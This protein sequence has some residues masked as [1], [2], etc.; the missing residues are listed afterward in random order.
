M[1]VIHPFRAVRPKKELVREVATLPY[2]VLNSQEAYELG[3]D[4][5]YSYLHI[6]KAEID[7]SKEILHDDK[8]VYE[9]AR[10]NF[11]KFKEKEWLIK[12]D[13]PNLY[14]YELTMNGR[15]QLGLVACTS[16]QEYLDGKIKK[17][18]FT[19]PEKELDR[20]RHSDACDANTSPIFLTYQGNIDLDSAMRKW[21]EIHEP[22]YDFTS[23]YEV[24]HRVWGIDDKEFTQQ[25]IDTFADEEALYIADG[26]HRTESAVKVGQLRQ[27]EYPNAKSDAEF[28]YFLSVIFPKQDLEILDYNRALKTPL[29]E[30]F[31][32]E[33]EKNFN[34]QKV[35]GLKEA[36]PQ[37]QHDFAF[38]T[39]RQWYVFTAK[40]E[41]LSSDEV[42]GLDVSILQKQ[43]LSPLFKISDPR[44]SSEIEFIGGIRGLEELEQRVNRGEF[45]S[46]FAL[47]PPTMDNLLSVADAGKI[48]PPKSTWFEPKLLSG[49]FIHEFETK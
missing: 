14:L 16:I 30:N 46:A 33:V 11:V 41:I 22:I 43:V 36:K 28:H 9:K 45:S 8:R 4:N 26:H 35:A 7:L 47:Y 44:T 2:D 12:E 15:S 40:K 29:P 32:Q 31:W 5:S 3:K 34:I 23:F 39:A 49:L 24:K 13:T 1:V 27:E 17:H 6:D 18:E 48:M 38:Y 20:I 37:K 21:S 25:I 19:R 42:D 10:E